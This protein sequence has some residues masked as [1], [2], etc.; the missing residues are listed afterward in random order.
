M[1]E[2][3]VHC[4][5]TKDLIKSKYTILLNNSK[6]ESQII[7]LSECLLL[8]GF[9]LCVEQAEHDVVLQDTEAGREDVEETR[10][11]E[12]VGQNHREYQA[13][14]ISEFNKSQED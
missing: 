12:H 2:L 7:N 1:W 3:K 6:I 9:L 13:I 11:E 8:D 4:L 5:N 14:P 10:E